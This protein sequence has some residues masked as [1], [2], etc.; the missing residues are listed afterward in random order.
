MASFS[1]FVAGLSKTTL[2]GVSFVSANG[3]IPGK[4]FSTGL[5]AVHVTT[6]VTNSFSVNVIGAVGGATFRIAGRTNITGVGTY[7]LPL[8]SLVGDS[9]TQ[10]LSQSAVPR[11]YGVEFASAIDAC[12]FDTANVYFTG[13]Y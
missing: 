13:N 12:G 6:G 11:P 7:T 3:E 1:G 9:G 10:I 2:T 4:C 5:F 8:F